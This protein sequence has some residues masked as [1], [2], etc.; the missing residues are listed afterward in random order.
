MRLSYK[1]VFDPVSANAVRDKMVVG[2][3]GKVDQQIVVY[4][5]LRACADILASEPPSLVAVL[6]VAE[7]SGKSLSRRCSEIFDFHCLAPFG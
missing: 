2:V 6:T 5:R 1:K 4:E 3:G 7:Y